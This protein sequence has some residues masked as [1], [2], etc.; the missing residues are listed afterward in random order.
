MINEAVGIL[1]DGESSVEDIDNA[2]KLVSNHPIGLLALADLIDNDVC[3]AIMEVLYDE[4]KD[5]KY[6]P[7]PY[8]KNIVR[9][10]LLGRKSK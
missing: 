10:G 5:S 8:L 1:A 2:M 9:Y 3:L 4:F 7:H 6:R